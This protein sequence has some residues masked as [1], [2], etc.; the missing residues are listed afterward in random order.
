MV[1]K[2][3]SNLTCS[4]AIVLPH[5]TSYAI[6]FHPQEH[7][8]KY[9]YF[10]QVRKSRFF[11]IRDSSLA[12]LLR[13]Y[14]L[15]LCGFNEQLALEAEYFWKRKW[16]VSK[17]PNPVDCAWEL[18]LERERVCQALTVILVDAFN[19]HISSDDLSRTKHKISRWAEG[20]NSDV[21]ELHERYPDLGK[22]YFFLPWR[23]F[24][25]I[26]PPCPEVIIS[27]HT[28]HIENFYK[29]HER[30]LSM[31]LFRSMDTSLSSVCRLYELG[32]LAHYS[33]KGRRI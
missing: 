25:F 14:E 31:P 12:S 4:R 6:L 1:W 19:Y 23:Y 26:H 3:S 22:L 17:I 18:D 24:Q 7:A 32:V 10:E 27:F 30:M 11:A 29:H 9:L 20:S 5:S 13:M 2:C 33:I 16:R 8:K 15:L 28:T 21:A